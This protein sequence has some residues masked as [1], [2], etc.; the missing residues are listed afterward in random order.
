MIPVNSCGLVRVQVGFRQ[1]EQEQKHQEI[2]YLTIT[3]RK[4]TLQPCLLRDF[5][6]LHFFQLFASNRYPAKYSTALSPPR[7]I[8]LFILFIYHSSFV[9]FG[10]Y[11][12]QATRKVFYSLVPSGIYLLIYFSFFFCDIWALPPTDTP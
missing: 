5:F 4:G 8:Y 7:F 6:Y 2:V 3:R 11:L 10:H 9:T 1:G 12:Q